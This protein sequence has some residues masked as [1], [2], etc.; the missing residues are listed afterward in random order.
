LRRRE[1]VFFA[2]SAHRLLY[3]ACGGISKLTCLKEE[4][5]MCELILT[6]LTV[7]TVTVLSAVLVAW[8]PMPETDPPSR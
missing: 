5:I 3:W 6:L 8:R 1:A 2:L 7:G 4:A